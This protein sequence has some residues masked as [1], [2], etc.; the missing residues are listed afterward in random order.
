MNRRD[1]RHIN[2]LASFKEPKKDKKGQS[3][4][5]PDLSAHCF[6]FISS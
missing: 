5:H 3:M 6:S 1:W 4:P 2:S